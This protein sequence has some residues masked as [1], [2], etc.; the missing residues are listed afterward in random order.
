MLRRRDQAAVAGVALLALAAMAVAWWRAGGAEGLVDIDQQ[1]R[2]SL[3]FV[4]DVNT[5]PWPEIAQLPD[6]GETLARRIVESR[7][8][9]GPFHSAAEL[10]RVSGIGPKTVERV[11]PFLRFQPP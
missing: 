8:Q 11:E 9:H 10:R 1:P 5:A 2:R 7:Q 4:V 3:E 6:V